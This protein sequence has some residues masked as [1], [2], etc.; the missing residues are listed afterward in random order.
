MHNDCMGIHIT[1]RDV[2][3]DVRNELASRAAREHKSM[4]EYL[5][6]Q[7]GRLAAKPSIDSWLERVRARKL[8]AGSRLT[9]KEIVA[10]RSADRR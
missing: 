5:R 4:Q 1:I 8:S 6:E 2:P 3:E 9:T 10:A 7:L